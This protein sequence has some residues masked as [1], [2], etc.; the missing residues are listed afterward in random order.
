MIKT[1]SQ[2]L[3]ET[4]NEDQILNQN[5]FSFFSTAEP[6]FTTEIPVPGPPLNF[7]SQNVN[8]LI[9][10]KK[11]KKT[12]SFKQTSRPLQ[13]LNTLQTEALNIINGHLNA[14]DRISSY[15]TT[16]DIKKAFRKASKKC[17]PDFGGTADLFI[18]LSKSTKILLDFSNSI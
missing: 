4:F 10:L 16:Q 12:Y 18:V 1:F 6:D 13:A 15:F 7:T 14:K 8:L 17:H 3:S 2:I 5:D 9:R 11:L